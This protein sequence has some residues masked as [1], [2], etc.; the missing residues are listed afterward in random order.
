VQ[1]ECPFNVSLGLD[2]PG[3]VFGERSTCVV[4]AK[5]FVASDGSPLTPASIA[6]RIDDINSGASIVPSTPVTPVAPSVSITVTAAQNRLLSNMRYLEEHQLTVTVTDSNG[7][8][9]NVPIRWLVK[10]IFPSLT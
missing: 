6:Y 8:V 4:T 3:S 10:R 7:N 9:A 2:A 5:F 1:A